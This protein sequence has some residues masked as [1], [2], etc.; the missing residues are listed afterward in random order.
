MR[1]PGRPQT[2]AQK[3]D[4]LIARAGIVEKPARTFLALTV[5]S[6][7]HVTLYADGGTACTCIAAR[8]GVECY[9]VIAARKIA[10]RGPFDGLEPRHPSKETP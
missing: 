3:A 6:E 10:A 9:A 7:H 2:K 5:G 4:D 8:H 1:E